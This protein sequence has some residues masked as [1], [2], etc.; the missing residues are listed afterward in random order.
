MA[1][2]RNDTSSKKKFKDKPKKTKKAAS[3]GEYKGLSYDSFEELSFLYWAFELKNQGYIKSI[4]RADSYLLSDP[5]ENHYA[6]QL[7]TKSKPAT[8]LIMHGHSYTPEFLIVWDHKKARD[9]VI[10]GLGGKKMVN[11][12]IVQ[13][14]DI[15]EIVS[16]IEIKPMWDQNNMERLFRLNQKWM[17]Q[18]H[19]IYVNLIKPQK[20]FQET[21]TPKEYMLTPT[22]SQR[23][24]AWKPRNLF[25][26]LNK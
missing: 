6:E 15:S 20:L 7:K 13:V 18:K 24:I 2:I 17:W 23:R 26:Y 22:G 25:D 11:P 21:F 9:R 5:L 10:C 1:K 19:G 16:V 12:I 3:T 14:N 8:Q 4:R